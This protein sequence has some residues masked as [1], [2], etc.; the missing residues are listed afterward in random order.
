MK[1]RLIGVGLGPGAP[2][3]MTG[4]AINTLKSAD[5]VAHMHATGRDPIAFGM[6]RPHLKNKIIEMPITIPMAAGDDQRQ[7]CYDAAIPAFRA[8]LDAGRDVTFVCEGDALFYG[9]FQYV[10]ERLA[11]DYAVEV[12]PAVTSVQACTA[13]AHLSLARMDDVFQALPAT[14]PEGVLAARL[15]DPGTAF[16]VMKLGRHADKAARVL[17]RAGRLA[18]AVLVE[19]ASGA[20]ETVMD[21]AAF[22]DTG[23]EASYFSMVLVPA[24][25]K[26]AVTGAPDGARVLCLNRAGLETA[27][28]LAAGL[29]GAQ[30]WARRGRVPEDAADRLFDDA[31]ETL[32]SVF[33]AGGPIVAVASAGVVIRALAPLLA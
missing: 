32:R 26:P 12:I 2:D 14:L 4:R 8:H 33:R 9:S 31:A 6:A 10:M 11:P 23:R 28:S 18:G 21:F 29:P 7:A 30:L 17:A 25:P 16:A 20:D 27:R 22:L 15:G 13:A 3:L 19:K 5:V 1:G 24:R